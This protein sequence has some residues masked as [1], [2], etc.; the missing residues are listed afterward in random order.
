M[1][2]NE[3]KRPNHCIQ[4]CQTLKSERLHI[5]HEHP[6][7]FVTLIICLLSFSPALHP[8]QLSEVKEIFKAPCI[9]GAKN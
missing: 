6:V 8:A 2:K 3:L 9:Y 7:I 1:K 5:F 4:Q